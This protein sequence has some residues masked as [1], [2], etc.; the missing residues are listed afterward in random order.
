MVK[1]KTLIIL[2]SSSGIARELIKKLKYKYKIISFY[3][4]NKVKINKVVSYKLNFNSKDDEIESKFKKIIEKNSKFIILNFASIKIDKI[5]Y[6]INKGEIE[7]T[8]NINTFAFLRIIQKFIP[9]MLREKWGRVINISSVG[10]LKGDKGTLLY[11]S[12]KNASASMMNVMSQ[13]YGKFNMTFNTLKLGNFNYGLFKKL[14]PNIKKNIINKIP[15]KKTGKIINIINAIEF[16]IESDYV[17]GSSISIDG[18][19]N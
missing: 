1:R 6:Y 12:S 19:M 9:K 3:N 2:G 18:G 15:S 8:F 5:S 14:N 13:E 17:N 4:N 10:G 16:L 11:S 7:K